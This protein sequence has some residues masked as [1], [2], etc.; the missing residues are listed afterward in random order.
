MGERD[1]GA[2]GEIEAT[3]HVWVSGR[4]QGV[5]FRASAR[6]EA[7]RRQVRGWIRNLPDDRVEAVFVGPEDQVRAMV[8]WCRS[9]PPSADVDEVEV[10]WNVAADLAGGER[11]FVVR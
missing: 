9:G 1:G 4:V 5:W 7:M 6:D 8:D 10:D 11:D 2:N 3:A